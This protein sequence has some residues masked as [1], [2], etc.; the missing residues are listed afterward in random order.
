VGDRLVQSLESSPFQF[1]F[2]IVDQEEPNAF[3][4]PGGFVYVS[5]G[6]IVLLE[7]EDELAG[8]LGHEI[9][10]VTLR[11]SASRQKKA[12]LP[13]ILALPGAIAS[14]S[15]A[16]MT[17]ITIKGPLMGAARAYLASYSRGQESEA[18]DKG[19]RLAAKAGYQP[20]ALSAILN[21]L[22][23]FVQA[24]YGDKAAK[25]NLFSDHPM[26][27]DRMKAIE[28]L[29][30][31]LTF[32]PGA[33]LVR[34]SEFLPTFEGIAFGPDPSNGVFFEQVFLHPGLMIHWELPAEWD[35][36]N[37]ESAAGAYTKDQ[38]TMIALRMAGLERQKDTLI[39]R[40]VNRYYA[41]TRK[42]PLSDKD[43]DLACGR[44]SEVI[45][46][47]SKKEDVIYTLW[48]PWKGYTY[49]IMGSGN[50][51]RVEAFRKSGQSFDQLKQSDRSKV[52]R[53]L[54]ATTQLS[55][56]ETLEALTSRTG[57]L[58]KPEFLALINEFAPGSS[59]PAGEP[60]KIIVRK[61]YFDN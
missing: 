51:S 35:Q 38:K 5:R 39:E 48:I 55:P 4:L 17:G 61:P 59:P 20:K 53:Y 46:P 28:A 52:S 45:L 2:S 27:P 10:H 6:L 23:R 43:I 57:N 54:L 40:F 9:S 13:T 37:Q 26:T 41:K 33:P 29:V 18:D 7:N 36:F 49:L 60:V 24:E 47:G 56:G 30:P 14:E 31:T 34:T 22:E 21:R 12:I 19:I 1:T 3:A 32:E 15:V 58:L 8:V 11:H 50:Q 25:Y 44:G 42:K 16:S